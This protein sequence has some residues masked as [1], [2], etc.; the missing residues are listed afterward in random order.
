MTVLCIVSLY[1]N[2]AMLY[3][4]GGVY[5]GSYIIIYYSH[6]HK[7]DT[8]FFTTL[9]FI[10]LTGLTLFFVC[11]RSA[12]LINVSIEKESHAKELLK[13]LENMVSIVEDNTVSLSKDIYGCNERIGILK[14]NSNTLSVAANEITNG[15]MDQSEGINN[16]SEMMNKADDN[17][18]EIN[19]LSKCLADI[20]ANTNQIVFESSEGI[21]NMDKQME[22]INVAVGESLATVQ[23]LNN[24]M[25]EVNTFLSSITEISEQTNLL[26]L[27]ASIEAA[28]A[29]ESGRGFAVVADEIKKLAEQSANSVK[30]IDNIIS[31][32]KDKMD[33]VIKKGND[34]NIAVKEGETITSMVHEGF[35]KIKLSFKNIDENISKELKM[36][37]SVSSIF[38][39]IR[40]QAEIIAS[41]SEEH[42]ASIEEML[43]TT[44]EQNVS[45]EDIYELTKN[46]NNSSVKLQE[47]IEKK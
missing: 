6:N 20:S 10:A 14:E 1:L 32:I 31:D 38:T 18:L 13:S 12:D 29:G 36:T 37:E 39:G 27:N 45:I 41:I 21:S 4:F 46:I 47:L 22:I 17:M 43:A 30:Q 33:S 23:D 8:D 35:E 3:S 7:F 28:R 19:N 16:I 44:E 25:D 11:K 5:S 26:A 2:K 24:S 40:K 42:S 9:G 15:V 34:E